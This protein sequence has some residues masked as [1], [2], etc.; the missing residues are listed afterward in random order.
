MI[1]ITGGGTIGH[2]NPALAV[3]REL[4]E[5]ITENCYWIGSRTGIERKAV[6]GSVRY[7]AI[8]CG[9]LRRYFSLRN[10]VD[11]L[12]VCAGVVGALGILL[13]RRP[14]VVFAKGGYVAVPVVLAAAILRVPVVCHE[15]DFTPGLATRISM[16]VAVRMCISD[17]ITL[18]FLPEKV[19]G[20][21]VVTGNPLRQEISSGRRA[22]G[23]AMVKAR[24]GEPVILFLGGS[25]GSAAI[26]ELVAECAGEL[27]GK[28]KCVIIHQYGEAHE[29]Q[30]W[31]QGH[32]ISGRQYHG[33]AY[34]REEL[35]DFLAAADIVVSRAGA[36]AVQELAAIGKCM[37]LIPFPKS[38]SRGEQLFNAQYMVE[39]GA[40][41]AIE[42]PTGS[43]LLGELDS[44]LRSP[45]T[46]EEMGGRAAGLFYSDGARRIA[47]V[48]C[49]VVGVQQDAVKGR[50]E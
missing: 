25:L 21:T 50:G 22:R 24:A 18:Q 39:R 14:A 4:P 13:F 42:E 2:V 23:R 47:E 48:I 5:S 16:R 17:E 32:G 40:A 41:V 38:A 29:K 36:N 27:S 11:M 44:L 37:V 12:L 6:A 46:R 9:K 3:L 7:F 34:L 28:H 19:R 15:S 31:A 49:Q 30:A 26:N 35:F 33:Y 8:P 43:Q 45:G 1:C 10:A 20:R